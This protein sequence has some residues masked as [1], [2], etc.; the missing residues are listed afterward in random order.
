MPLTRELVLDGN[1]VKDYAAKAYNAL[2]RWCGRRESNPYGI[3]ASGVQ[4]RCGYQ[5]RHA[6]DHLKARPAGEAAARAP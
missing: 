6:R 2:G 3:A 5:F 4:V 1:A